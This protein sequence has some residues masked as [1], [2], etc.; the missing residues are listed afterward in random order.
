MRH[1]VH[2]RGMVCRGHRRRLA[3]RQGEHTASV[4]VTVDVVAVA[5][6]VVAIAESIFL[7]M[8]MSQEEGQH[9]SR[10]KQMVHREFA[11]GTESAVEPA[12]SVK[13]RVKG[14]VNGRVVE[15]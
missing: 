12:G 1:A 6:V 10:P 14:R 15:G 7:V 4:V 13:G 11:A 9:P 5:V 3:M 2:V 8:Y